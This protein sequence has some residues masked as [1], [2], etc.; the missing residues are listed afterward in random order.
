MSSL[1]FPDNFIDA[2]HSLGI[3]TPKDPS[4]GVKAGVFWGP[5]SLNAQNESRSYA[6]V[7]HYDRVIRYRPNYHVL[8]N[9]A[10]TRITIRDGVAVGV[11]TVNRM[12]NDTVAFLASSEVILAA[13]AVHS[14]QILQLSGIGPKSVLNPLNVEMIS[15]L[16]G[17]GQNFQDHPTVY[18]TFNCESYIRSLGAVIV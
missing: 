11:E 17:V 8:E 10:V 6:R 3:S 16:P 1:P 12:T 5:S 9:T 14:P 7:A 15:E 4:A 2:W 18:M 13:G